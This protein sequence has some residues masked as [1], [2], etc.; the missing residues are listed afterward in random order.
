[1]WNEAD[2]RALSHFTKSTSGKNLVALN[3]IEIDRLETIIGEVPK[4]RSLARRI[5]KRV[6][7]FNFK[8]T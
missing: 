7:T 5:I 1:V 2:S 4:T 3:N 8:R 6:I